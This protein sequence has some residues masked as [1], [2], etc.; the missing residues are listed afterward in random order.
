MLKV[1]NLVFN[2]DLVLHFSQKLEKTAFFGVFLYI[3]IVKSRK[4]QQVLS[5]ASC[6]GWDLEISH[7]VSSTYVESTLK[8]VEKQYFMYFKVSR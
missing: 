4:S 7:E 1:S 2:V 8:K 5:V 3:Y 6:K